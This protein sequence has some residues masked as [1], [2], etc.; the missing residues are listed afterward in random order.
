MTSSDA[1]GRHI[2][3]KDFSFCASEL[4]QLPSNHPCSRNHGHN[5]VVTVAL[6][7]DGLD[8]SGFVTDFGELAVFGDYLKSTFDHALLN[9]VVDF[10]PTSELLAC[11]LGR[12]AI[13][14]D[15]PS[16]M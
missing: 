13:G 5:F 9:D 6:T 16:P 7:A 11:H 15:L 2:I 3:A 10:P 14:T 12:S 8:P 4:R 1:A